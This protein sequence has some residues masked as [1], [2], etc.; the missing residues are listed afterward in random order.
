MRIACQQMLVYS[1][2]GLLG[3]LIGRAAS[4]VSSETE[5]GITTS[6]ILRAQEHGWADL[7]EQASAHQVDCLPDVAETFIDE[8]EDDSD[9]EE[10]PRVPAAG[11]SPSR[12]PSSSPA[13]GAYLTLLVLTVAGVRARAGPSD[14]AAVPDSREVIAAVRKRFAEQHPNVT[15]EFDDITVLCMLV[16]ISTLDC[17]LL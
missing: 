16:L 7:L 3:N 11:R 5:F 8:N 6:C 9:G 2:T 14:W 13:P 17:L 15:A 1:V 4:A 10:G 12:R